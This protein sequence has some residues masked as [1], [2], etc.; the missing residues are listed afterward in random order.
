M[1]GQ[2]PKNCQQICKVTTWLQDWQA[3]A[4]CTEMTWNCASK[5]CTIMS[6]QNMIYFIFIQTEQWKLK[7]NLSGFFAI[8]YKKYTSTSM[9]PNVGQDQE[10]TH[11]CTHNTHPWCTHVI[12]THKHTHT[13]TPFLWFSTDSLHPVE[14]AE[15]KWLNNSAHFL[16]SNGLLLL[17]VVWCSATGL[18]AVC[19]QP[20][21]QPTSHSSVHPGWVWPQFYLLPQS[22]KTGNYKEK[23]IKLHKRLKAALK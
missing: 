6:H 5:R 2:A 15:R 23:N 13:Y 22:T 8:L 21:M 3:L 10:F 9:K 12:T 18:S 19:T 17:M 16:N 4:S 14:N 1:C 11:T 7:F 20:V